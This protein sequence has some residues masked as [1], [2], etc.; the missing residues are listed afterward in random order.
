[1]KFESEESAHGTFTSLCYS[2]EFLMDMYSKIF[3][4][5]NG[6]LSMKLMS[7][8]LLKRTFLVNRANGIA[9]FFKFNKTVIRNDFR[10][11]VTHML[12]YLFL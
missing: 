4:T 2:F 9:T 12:A 7:V 8:H 1:M 6:V 5:P 3:H 10:E 11:E